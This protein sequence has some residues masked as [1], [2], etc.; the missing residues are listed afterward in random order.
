MASPLIKRANVNLLIFRVAPQS[1]LGDSQLC[2]FLPP[3]L[4]F[5]Y[6]QMC[7]RFQER[8]LG[9]EAYLGEESL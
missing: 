7:L 4:F 8:V 1:C 6:Q 9:P 5:A 2:N 3:S